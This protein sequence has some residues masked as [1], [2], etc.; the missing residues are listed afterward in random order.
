MFLLEEPTRGI[1]VGAKRR[2]MRAIGCKNQ[3]VLW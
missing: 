1:D 2:Y 3:K